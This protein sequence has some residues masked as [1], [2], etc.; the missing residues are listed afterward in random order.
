[1]THTQEP[2][3]ICCEKGKHILIGTKDGVI[4]Y[5]M[6]DGEN[7]SEQA[8]ANFRRIVACVNACAGLSNKLLTTEGYSLKEEL[9]DLDAQIGL[10]LAA[11]R[12]IKELEARI[13]ELEGKNEL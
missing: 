6:Q 13:T 8:E 7:H 9:D 12:Y 11:E 10:R 5:W 1:M 4:A 3:E 2:W